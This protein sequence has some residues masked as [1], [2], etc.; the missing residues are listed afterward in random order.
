[1]IRT[2]QRASVY[3]MAGVYPHSPV[4]E[5]GGSGSASGF[6]TE[7]LRARIVLR[8]IALGILILSA[9]SPPQPNPEMV[10]VEAGTFLMGAEDGAADERPVHEVTLTR[11]ILVASTEVTRSEYREFCDETGRS[12]PRVRGEEN[13][14]FPVIGVDWYDAI[15]YSNWMS[16]RG[17]L[18]PA[19]FGTRGDIDCAFDSNGYRLPTE[20]VW[21]YAAQGT[22][23][24]STRHWGDVSGSGPRPVATLPANPRGLYDMAGNSFAWCWDWYDTGYYAR[25]LQTDPSGPESPVNPRGPEKVRRSGSWR[26]PLEAA[27]P[28]SRSFDNTLY[29]GDNGFRLVRTVANRR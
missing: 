2:K 23:A 22:D 20:A 24:V 21:E 12:M 19:Y 29:A 13:D 5:P 27:Q 6:T 3:R 9:C 10:L 4:H 14:R 8:I 17:G 1:M 28:T 26:E 15:E 7:I 18:E 16:D 25:S 11:T